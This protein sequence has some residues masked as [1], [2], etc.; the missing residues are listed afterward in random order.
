MKRIE[1]LKIFL[2]Q[3]SEKELVVTATGMT[4]REA[5]SVKD[6]EENFYML[7]SMGLVTPLSLG[8]AL[9]CPDKKII[10]IEGDGS[11]LLNLGS[12]A[13]VGAEKPTN[14]LT[15]VLDNGTYEST[16]G[17]KCISQNLDLSK[18]AKSLGYKNVFSAAEVR[19]LSKTIEKLLKIKG[20]SFL[21]VRIESSHEKGIPRVSHTP[22]QIK[23]RFIKA[24]NS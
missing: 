5:F 21:R 16:G 22:E 15:I 13:M 9:N 10:A 14:L 23:E 19:E 20:P 18:I 24:L 3:L 17:Q 8:L 4:S 7:G 12:L 6:R 2:K 1:A 11:V